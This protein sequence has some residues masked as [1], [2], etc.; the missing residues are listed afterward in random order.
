M[1][2]AARSDMETRE[3]KWKMVGSVLGGLG[4]IGSLVFVALEIRQNTEAVRS[5]TIQAIS[6]QSFTAVA[7][8][9]ENADLRTAYEAASTGAA[10]T[11]EQRFQLKMFYLGIMRLQQNRY[12]QSQL[13]VLDMNTLLFVG[14]RG[15]A[16][17]LPFF[18]EYWAEDR[19][20]YPP[21][22]Q[23]FVESVLLPRKGGSP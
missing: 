23:D 16:Y 14:G 3:A 7:Q 17:D 20:Q 5:A 22:F 18:A 8:L 10:L 9:V 1:V 11:P 12:L 6:E 13:G 2:A 19:D 15:G 4:V 21:E